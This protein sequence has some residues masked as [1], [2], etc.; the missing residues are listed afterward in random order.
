MF[1]DIIEIKNDLGLVVLKNIRKMS[2]WPQSNE[3]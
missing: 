2:F 1:N 3:K